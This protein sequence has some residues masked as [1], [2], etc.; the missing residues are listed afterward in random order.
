MP[1]VV[2]DEDQGGSVP[3]TAFVLLAAIE[4]Q[5]NEHARNCV[6]VVSAIVINPDD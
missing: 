4:Q 2:G 1:V 5:L 3:Q 6:G